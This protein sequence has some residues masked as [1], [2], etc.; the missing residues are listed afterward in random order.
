[1]PPS[2]MP[3]S[4]GKTL[5]RLAWMFAA[6]KVNPRLLLQLL[7]LQLLFYPRRRIEGCQQVALF[8]L[9]LLLF[10]FLLLSVRIIIAI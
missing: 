7:V 4:M 1:M 9:L 6:E 8:L 2:D 5:N 3:V 10:L